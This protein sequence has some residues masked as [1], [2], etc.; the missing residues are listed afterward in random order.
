MW[1]G[2]VCKCRMKWRYP[3]TDRTE[4]IDNNVMILLNIEA[5]GNI[6]GWHYRWNMLPIHDRRILTI[7]C[8][9]ICCALCLFPVQL[10][11]ECEIWKVRSFTINW[12]LSMLLSMCQMIEV[13]FS[14]FPK[15]IRQHHLS[16]FV[17][18]K[19][20][21]LLIVYFLFIVFVNEVRCK[22]F[23]FSFTQNINTNKW[24]FF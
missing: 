10:W 8:K 7:L 21:T 11:C 14:H 4:F 20:S 5:D 19:M 17:D 18:R 13:S 9:C 24:H 6:F 15:A 1:W 23:V 2:E 22:I 16:R 12:Y 3:R